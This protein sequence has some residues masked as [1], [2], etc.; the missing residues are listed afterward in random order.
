MEAKNQSNLVPETP[1][2]LMPT[3]DRGKQSNQTFQKKYK[4]GSEKYHHKVLCN[5]KTNEVYIFVERCKGYENTNKAKARQLRCQVEIAKSVNKI[6]R[7][8]K[9]FNFK[10]NQHHKGCWYKECENPDLLVKKTEIKTDKD[11]SKLYKK[12]GN[13]KDYDDYDDFVNKCIEDGMKKSKKNNY[14]TDT[15]LTI[16]NHIQDTELIEKKIKWTDIHSIDEYK[17]YILNNFY[18]NFD[19]DKMSFQYDFGEG[20]KTYTIFNTE[21]MR[22]VDETEEMNDDTDSEDDNKKITITEV[23]KNIPKKKVSFQNEETL[24]IVDDSSD[25][26]EELTPIVEK[27]YETSF[28]EFYDKHMKY[29]KGQYTKHHI[30]Y[31]SYRDWC[32]DN[33]KQQK[34]LKYCVEYLKSKDFKIFSNTKVGNVWGHLVIDM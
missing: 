16:N 19:Y 7:N 33:E 6:Y 24:D 18:K 13:H 5:D 4:S 17:N 28:D 34:K 9:A 14:M 29:V 10:Y 26:E 23:K 2:H 21:F 8:H 12:I 32:K 1:R 25:E 30:M 27:T 22:Y 3:T 20:F 31:K 11:G 15:D